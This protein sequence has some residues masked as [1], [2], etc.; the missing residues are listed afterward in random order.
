MEYNLYTPYEFLTQLYPRTVDFASSLYS[1]MSPLS[2]AASVTF[3]DAIQPVWVDARDESENLLGNK[4]TSSKVFR[5]S[6]DRT[7]QAWVPASYEDIRNA[8]EKASRLSERHSKMLVSADGLVRTDCAY[9]TLLTEIGGRLAVHLRHYDGVFNEYE[10]VRRQMEDR[11]LTPI[12]FPTNDNSI[13]IPGGSNVPH[14]VFTRHGVL[15]P[16]IESAKAKNG[17]SN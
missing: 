5:D 11:N 9:R 14:R 2:E 3:P 4:N 10:H 12:D 6:M 13:P 16:G 17:R 8:L 1:N 15:I 7:A